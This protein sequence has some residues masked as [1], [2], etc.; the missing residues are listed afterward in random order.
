M[1]P[2]TAATKGQFRK[3]FVE[4]YR[5]V[6]TAIVGY[7]TSVPVTLTVQFLNGLVFPYIHIGI[8]TMILKWSHTSIVGRV[9]GVLNPMFVGTYCTRDIILRSP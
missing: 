3:D 5:S 8:S 4:G 1:K 7:S 9:N 6:C 2:Q